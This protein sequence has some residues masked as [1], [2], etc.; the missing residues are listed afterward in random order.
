MATT[1]ATP[2]LE[3][4]ATR[5][6]ELERANAGL[7]REVATLRA[8]DVPGGRPAHAVARPLA[9]R[10]RG[11]DVSAGL[12]PAPAGAGQ[13]GPVRT[14]RRR[15][16]RALLGVAAATVGAGAALEAETGRAAADV[17]PLD[18]YGFFLSSGSYP[19]AVRAIA[20][21]GARGIDVNVVGA[22]GI[23]VNVVGA[24]GVRV[25]SESGTAVDA[26]SSGTNYPTVQVSNI[27]GGPGIIAAT[28]SAAG[29]SAVQGV[30]D[31]GAGVSGKSSGGAGVSATSTSGPGVVGMS[32]T[33]DGVLGFSSGYGG[34]FKGASAP[35]HLYP[36][37]L[38]GSP[39]TGNHQTGELYVDSNGLLWF[40][41]GSGTPGTWKQV[42]LI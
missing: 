33:G 20:T 30:N 27:G 9:R 32:G 42:A 37:Q 23:D 41:A 36:S 31:G 13:H 6:D 8:G 28:S 35:I 7:R 19:P 14:N 3:A 4:L 17:Q 25:V 22:R 10:R 34:N 16:L 11:H 39:S 1:Q 21:N 40:C 15:V 38:P 12:P 29:T 26:S 5:L 18:H 2:T 24:T